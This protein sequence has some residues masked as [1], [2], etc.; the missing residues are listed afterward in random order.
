MSRSS[1]NDP[2]GR[3]WRHATF[4]RIVRFGVV[5]FSGFCV[6]FGVTGLFRAFFEGLASLFVLNYISTGFGFCAGATSNY[7]LNRRWTWRSDNPN[8]AREFAKFFGVSL[9]GL[10]IHYVVLA[11][12]LGLAGLEFGSWVDNYWTSKLVATAVVMVWNFL[13][14]NFYTFRGQR[15]I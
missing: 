1:T 4:R 15:S 10:G 12:C 11:F 5:G 8:V 14:N 7:I 3:L 2:S 13:A 9:I 6:D